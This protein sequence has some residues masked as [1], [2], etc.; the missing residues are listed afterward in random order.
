MIHHASV[1]TNDLERAK[2]FYDAVLFE[3]GFRLVK[4]SERILG[5]GLTEVLFSVERPLN[6]QPAS[7]GNGGHVAFHAGHRSSVD[8]CHAAGK[9][10]GGRS[11][12]PPGIREAYDQNYYAAFL[13]DPDGNKIEIVTFAAD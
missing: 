7:P 4:Q 2:A 6:G 13:L 3:L 1:G 12:G 11:D 10:N 5:Y 9:A 8:A